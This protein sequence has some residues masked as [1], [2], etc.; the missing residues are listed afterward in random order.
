MPLPFYI[1]DAEPQPLLRLQANVMTDGIVLCVSFHRHAVDGLGIS[2]ILQALSECCRNPDQPLERL[3]T[4]SESEAQS[5]TRI[6]QSTN[7]SHPC[8]NDG[9]GNYIEKA[10]PS[11]K[12]GALISRRFCLDAAKIRRLRE[13]YNTAARAGIYQTHRITSASPECNATSW[14]GFSNNEVVTALIW[15]CGVR[16]RSSAIAM[17]KDGSSSADLILSLL[18]AVDVRGL[19]NIPNTYMGNAIVTPTSTY[20]FKGAE[21]HDAE[22][23]LTFKSDTAD[24]GLHKIDSNDITLLTN[25]ALSGQTTYYSANRNHVRYAISHIMASKDWH[26][27]ARLGG[28]SITNLRRAPGYAMDFGPC[29]GT[30]FG[31]DVPDN[32]ADGVCWIAPQRSDSS[33]RLMGYESRGFW[34]VRL[35]LGPVAMECLS[36]D[37][38]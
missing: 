29:L 14:Q 17:K 6:S 33:A 37:R 5:R 28:M 11:S 3:S 30:A 9:D 8:M 15:L 24:Y 34:E 2:S 23:R 35:T 20:P 31:I 4:S 26:L 16:A 18:F 7:E 36:S 22:G 21:L 12:L 27:P 1:P 38:I 25:Q 13:A 10:A 32:R 19:L